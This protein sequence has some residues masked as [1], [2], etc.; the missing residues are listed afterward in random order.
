MLEKYDHR[1]LNALQRAHHVRH[2]VYVHTYA[3]V[4]ARVRARVYIR[5]HKDLCDRM[6]GLIYTLSKGPPPRQRPNKRPDATSTAETKITSAIN[7]VIDFA[8]CRIST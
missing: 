6:R 1:S 5:D 7:D 2:V 8:D 4:F 3:P